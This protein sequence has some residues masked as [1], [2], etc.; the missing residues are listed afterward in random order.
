MLTLISQKHRSL[1][2]P[3]FYTRL[4]RVPLAYIHLGTVQ[5]IL[6]M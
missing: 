1:N 4:F 5:L 2:E 6:Y 3:F